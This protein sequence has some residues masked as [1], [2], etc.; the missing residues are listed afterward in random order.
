MKFEKI[1]KGAELTRFMSDGWQLVEQR[2]FKAGPSDFYVFLRV[3]ENGGR[4]IN[5]HATCAKRAIAN[6]RVVEQRRVWLQTGTLDKVVWK[7]PEG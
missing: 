2:S 7:L 5:V 3:N 6:K 4:R 1:T